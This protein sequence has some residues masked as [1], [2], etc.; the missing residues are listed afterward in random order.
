MK[1]E[2]AKHHPVLEDRYRSLRFLVLLGWALLMLNHFAR[3]PGIKLSYVEETIIA[4]GLMVSS[5]FAMP[6]RRPQLAGLSILMAFVIVMRLGQLSSDQGLALL[7][8]LLMIACGYGLWLVPHASLRV[9]LLLILLMLT[10]VAT[11]LVFGG[12]EYIIDE[13]LGAHP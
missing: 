7:G 5:W 4:F 12:L 2:S 3:I 1:A 8:L 13:Q 9:R 6:D 11:E 10:I